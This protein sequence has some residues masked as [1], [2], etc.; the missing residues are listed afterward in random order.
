MNE[1]ISSPDHVEVV[2]LQ[3]RATLGAGEAGLRQTLNWLGRI[4]RKVNEVNGLLG[5]LGARSSTAGLSAQATA[6]HA[7]ALAIE[8]TAQAEH[9]LAVVRGSQPRAALPSGAAVMPTPLPSPTP[10]TAVHTTQSPNL[11]NLATAAKWI[12][13]YQ[14]IDLAIRG[15]SHSLTSLTE[16]DSQIARLSQVFQ[17]AGG[18]ARQ[19][20]D[21]VLRLA[22]AN[23]RSTD[24]AMESAIQWARLGLSRVQ[25]N[26]AV[27]V[28]LQ[29]ANVAEL[30]AADA[31]ERL[32]ALTQAY[33]LS[34]H[35][36]A[37]TLGMLN[38]VSN[39]FNVTNS[40]MLDGLSKTAAI[41]SQAGVPLAELVGIIGGAVG[42]TGQAGA[43]IGT[44][45]KTII[46]RVS[47][48][49]IQE[50]L[51]EQFQIE[52]TTEGGANIKDFSKTLAETFVA[53]QRLNAAERQSLLFNTAGTHQA[54]RLAA[55][56]DSYVRGQ[57]LAIN[58]QLSLNSAERE[59]EKITAALKAQLTGLVSEWDRFVNIQG[60]R[61]PSQA[62]GGITEALRNLI[63]LANTPIGGAAT[64]GLLALFTAVSAKV[65]LTA[66]QMKNLAGAGVLVGGMQGIRT[67]IAGLN[68]VMTT[69]IQRFVDSG[70]ALTSTG[71][72]V[73][74]A[75]AGLLDFSR[76]AGVAAARSGGLAIGLRTASFA[77]K[78]LAVS[79][80]AIWRVGLPML[81][82]SAGIWAFNR[83]MA[84]AAESAAQAER[85]IA[86]FNDRA[87]QAAA[88]AKSAAQ[89]E[90][91]FETVAKS[92]PGARPAEQ[93]KMIEGV[94][95]VAFLN[96]DNTPDTARNQALEHELKTLRDQGEVNGVLARLETVK[97]DIALRGM[98]AR[99]EE[100][101]L[102]QKQTDEIRDQIEE[103]KK[104]GKTK[105]A[106]ELE[107]KL[108]DVGDKRTSK[109]VEHTSEMTED[110]REFLETDQKHLNFLEREKL[111]AQSISDIFKEMPSLGH[112]D[113]LDADVASVQAQITHSEALLKLLKNDP[114]VAVEA[115]KE[116]TK[117]G[118]SILAQ[119]SDA[120]KMLAE[121]DAEI[122]K[123]PASSRAAAESRADRNRVRSTLSEELQKTGAG[124]VLVGVPE[125][126]GIEPEST[127]RQDN[128]VLGKPINE[129]VTAQVETAERLMEQRAALET[130]LRDLIAQRD[131]NRAAPTDSE[132]R[133]KAKV[134]DTEKTLRE[135]RSKESALSSVEN[136]KLQ[137][138]RDASEITLRH[139]KLGIESA[140][141]GEN[142]A[143][144]LQSQIRFLDQVI[145][146]KNELHDL[147]G[148]LLSG[149]QQNL[150]ALQATV[151]KQNLLVESDRLRVKLSLDLVNTQ[152]EMAREY[153]RSILMAGPGDMLRKLA[154]KSMVDRGRMN[155]GGFMA[156]SPEARRDADQY[157][158]NINHRMLDFRTQLRTLGDER[159]LGRKLQDE[160]DATS[161]AAGLRRMSGPRFTAPTSDAISPSAKAAA[162]SLSA[163]H[164]VIQA[165][166]L[167]SLNAFSARLD[168]IAADPA[169]GA[170]R[171]RA[172]VP[173]DYGK[174]GA[175][176][177]VGA[178]MF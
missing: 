67:A 97:R 174:I 36:L 155:L 147:D 63:H 53:F 172:T 70:A 51:R 16:T 26:E 123:V 23:G 45:I 176:A 71:A 34:V 94:A 170:G 116:R 88:A 135:L 22:A 29:A 120:R 96:P 164:S 101:T 117:T 175:V 140:A 62:L 91:L 33:G 137:E 7:V 59:N 144:Q 5:T 165:V 64:T 158:P 112:T 104:A 105:H 125:F 24:E 161:N 84:A 136:R 69:A 157:D 110:R 58:A 2:E 103:A 49:E 121:T 148:H 133:N 48:P 118:A 72:S 46:G 68:G 12:A 50:K 126:F 154:V 20:T 75:A 9:K 61:G 55:I 44:V 92:L 114:G 42:T 76:A 60:N 87:E 17:G 160:R 15:V 80:A 18:S 40:A 109:I 146:R 90:R 178:S 1:N 95:S 98:V 122:A 119:I 74:I 159:S 28:S 124:N 141:V 83:A 32:S 115:E 4:E 152:R 38:A 66:V 13:S 86:G 168:L 19:L 106:L 47:N 149:Q 89:A 139:G 93:N 21:D 85:K 111:L 3:M 129:R 37:G 150:L 131:Q 78:A 134:E 177:F 143:E 167:P 151:E 142:P 11:G 132:A 130:R 10:T 77:A 128:S 171:G 6:Q 100:L 35:Q 39:T 43:N 138:Q 65:A 166:V 156:L 57:V 56:L 8:R 54:S 25:I 52:V 173:S 99:H 169:R 27:R 145:A 41:A 79:L 82:I 81:L 107:A 113:K 30:S 102:L 108:A 163:V 31:T 162:A 73:R 153:Q 127:F 14:A